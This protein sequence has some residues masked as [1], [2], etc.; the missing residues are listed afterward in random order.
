MP[1]VMEYVINDALYAAWQEQQR[2]LSGRFLPEDRDLLRRIA[3]KV[4]V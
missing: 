1:M 2:E 3:A 4:G